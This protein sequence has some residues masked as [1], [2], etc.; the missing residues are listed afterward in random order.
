VANADN[1]RSYDALAFRYARSLGVS[2]TAGSDIHAVEDADGAYGVYL[3]TK[4]VSVGEYA[5]AVRKG[6]LS[7]ENLRMPAGRCEWT[8]TETV[9]LPVSFRDRFDKP[10]QPPQ[11]PAVS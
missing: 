11:P 1:E 2:L 4:M 8:G 6:G 9:R 3:D 7:L 10:A 5:E